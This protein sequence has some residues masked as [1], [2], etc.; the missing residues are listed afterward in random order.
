MSVINIFEAK[1]NLSKLVARAEQGEEIIIAR[2]G[3]PA[4]RLTQLQPAKKPIVFGLLKGKIHVSDD[5]DDDLPEDL[6]AAFNHGEIFPPEPSE[7]DRQ[8][9]SDLSN[10]EQQP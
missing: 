8:P 3:K 5:F 6:L 4:A 9:H 10:K 7:K 1:T 2:N